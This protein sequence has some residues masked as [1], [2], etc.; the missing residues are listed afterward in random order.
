MLVKTKKPNSKT[1]EEL[2]VAQFNTN[3]LKGAMSFLYIFYWVWNLY[4][5]KQ[6]IQASRIR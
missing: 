4:L 3:F 2:F 1:Q 6:E 5:S